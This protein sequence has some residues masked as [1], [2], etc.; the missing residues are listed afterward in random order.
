MRRTLLSIAVA[1][2]SFAVTAAVL[3][4]GFQLV[5]GSSEAPVQGSR[6]STSERVDVPEASPTPS[7][8]PDNGLARPETG[9][10]GSSGMGLGFGPGGTP[11]ADEPETADPE[12]T[13]GVL[14]EDFKKLGLDDPTTLVDESVQTA[15]DVAGPALVVGPSLCAV[16]R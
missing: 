5:A 8:T 12:P 13:A 2:G 9:T 16:V 4:G 15:C 7:Q 3:I 14:S 6:A 10:F 1:V 11:V